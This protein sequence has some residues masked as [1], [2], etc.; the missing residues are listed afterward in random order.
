MVDGGFGVTV[1]VARAI[2][3]PYIARTCTSPWRTGTIR[4][5]GIAHATSNGAALKNT[6]AVSMVAPFAAFTTAR[7]R[8]V[9]PT[10][11]FACSGEIVM[12]WALAST[13]SARSARGRIIRIGISR[14]LKELCEYY[15]KCR[16]LWNHALPDHAYVNGMLW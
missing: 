4:P 16:T 1:S 6:C 5:S 15:T 2:W 10:V 8:T 9:S 11:A 13:G 3:L 7:N 14:G 12:V